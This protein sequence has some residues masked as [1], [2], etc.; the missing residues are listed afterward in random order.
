MLKSK[1]AASSKR[2]RASAASQLFGQENKDKI[3]EKMAAAREGEVDTRD[4]LSLYQKT[5]K[6]LF[7]ALPD[8]DRDRYEKK[9]A[10]LKAMILTGPSSSQISE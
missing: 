4:N 7:E 3:L 9:A 10:A 8:T 6:S 2:P 1:D 5:Q